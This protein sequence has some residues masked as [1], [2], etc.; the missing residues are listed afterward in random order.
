MRCSSRAASAGPPA[1]PSK[2]VWAAWREASFGA[3]QLARRQLGSQRIG[4]FEVGKNERNTLPP[5]GVAERGRRLHVRRPDGPWTVAFDESGRNQLPKPI[6]IFSPD[7]A[8]IGP[9]RS[10]RVTN[11][12]AWIRAR[13]HCLAE[14]RRRVRDDIADGIPA[15]H[16]LDNPETRPP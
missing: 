3:F 9:L 7:G 4:V 11:E 1:K 14:A 6:R 10:K 15:L 8:E 16:D 5:A 12:Q 13:C 2:G